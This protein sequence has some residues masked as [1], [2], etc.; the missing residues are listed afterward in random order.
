MATE[1]YDVCVL[2]KVANKRFREDE[3]KYRH[4]KIETAE[5][6]YDP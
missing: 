6:S 2:Q 1:C 5:E 4:D 3:E